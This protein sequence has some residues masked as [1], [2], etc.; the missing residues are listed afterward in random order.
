MKFSKP[1]SNFQGTLVFTGEHSMNIEIYEVNTDHILGRIYL[2]LP[3]YK[4]SYLVESFK[5]RIK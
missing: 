3:D 4:K 5:A 1:G 2:S